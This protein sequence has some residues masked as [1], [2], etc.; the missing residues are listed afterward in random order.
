MS[1]PMERAELV[2]TALQAEQL[3]S[4]ARSW[5]GTPFCAGSGVKGAGVCCHRYVEMVYKGAHWL[6]GDLVVPAGESVWGRVQKR[7]LIGDWLDGCGDYFVRVGMDEGWRVGDLA[8]FRLGSCVHH[9]ALR[10]DG[11]WIHAVQG[12]G[13]VEVREIP[14]AWR[15]R[16][17]MRWRVKLPVWDGGGV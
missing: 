7:S 5:I 12:P 13:V 2:P 14:E 1:A 15:R 4:V 11:S 3:I 9:L 17:A 6:P 16:L 8:G 10:L